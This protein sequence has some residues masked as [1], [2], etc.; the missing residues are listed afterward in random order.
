MSKVKMN[1]FVVKKNNQY[2][3]NKKFFGSW[4]PHLEQALRFR[5]K[6]E[7]TEYLGFPKEY[8]KEILMLEV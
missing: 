7:P 8:V 3:T 1:Y 4:T 6:F 2:Y 5:H